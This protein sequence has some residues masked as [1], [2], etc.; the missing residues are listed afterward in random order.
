MKEEYTKLMVQQ[1]T[2]PEGDA[3]FFEKLETVQTNK[4]IPAWK[5]AVIAACIALMIPV[6]VWAA[7]IPLPEWSRRIR[8]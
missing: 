4:R 3:A 2:S 7:W 6:T 1:H 8:R 5:V